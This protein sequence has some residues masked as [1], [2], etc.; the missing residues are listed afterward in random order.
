MVSLHSGTASEWIVPKTFYEKE[1][2]SKKDSTTHSILGRIHL[3]FNLSKRSFRSN[4]LKRTRFFTKL[5]RS[6]RVQCTGY[7]IA[8]E[9][10]LQSYCYVHYGAIG[11]HF[12]TCFRSRPK[13][14]VLGAWWSSQ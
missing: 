10:T 8:R 6:K 12:G 11:V 3:S 5:E 13:T 4:P 9:A 2:W 7:A 1:G 14:L